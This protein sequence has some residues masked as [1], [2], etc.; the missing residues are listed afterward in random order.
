M[1]T[2]T[3]VGVIVVRAAQVGNEIYL[4]AAQVD[5]TFSVG[6]AQQTIAFTSITDKTYGDKPFTLVGTASSGLA[7]AFRVKSGPA[8]ITGKTLSVVGVGNITVEATQAGNAAFAAAPAVEQ[9]FT[10]GKASPVITFPELNTMNEGDAPFTLQASSTNPAVAITFS[11]SDS[12]IVSV[13]YTNGKWLATALAPGQVQ[14][15]AT[16]AGSDKYLAANKVVRSLTVQQ[17]NTPVTDVQEPKEEKLKI[18]AVRANKNTGMDYNPWLSDDLTDLVEQVWR[19]NN[20]KYVDVRLQLEHKSLVH[21]LSF[22]DLGVIFS[23]NPAEIYAINGTEKTLLGVF[24]GADSKAWVNL[25]LKE[26]IIAEAIIIRKYGNNIPQKINVYGK[27]LPATEQITLPVTAGQEKP[28]SFIWTAYP[29]PTAG[30]LKVT[31]SP[32]LEGEITIDLLDATGQKL[33][34]YNLQQSFTGATQL[35][36]MD[37]FKNGIYFLHLKAKGVWEVKKIQK[38]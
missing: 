31:V 35:I 11:S 16:Q 17:T 10:V 6:K 19:P 12:K 9:S 8:T 4:P 24:K 36:S 1:L 14:I 3:G 13:A 38:Q 18:V 25:N 2:L 26:P 30:Q 23:S 22:Y 33:Q 20:N 7:V 37:N 32:A 28:S 21:K 34:L 15:T 29:N 27:V 5:R